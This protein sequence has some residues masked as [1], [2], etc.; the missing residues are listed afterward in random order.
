MSRTVLD[1]DFNAFFGAVIGSAVGG[2]L[3]R[4]EYQAGKRLADKLSRR[5]LKES[6]G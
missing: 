4:L 2:I 1:I 5:W 6:A 3:G